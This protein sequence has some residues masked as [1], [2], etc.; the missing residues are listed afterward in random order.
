MA[1]C[2]L[3]LLLLLLRSLLSVDDVLFIALCSIDNQKQ[4][5]PVEYR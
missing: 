4:A 3:Q 1:M 2:V 5:S